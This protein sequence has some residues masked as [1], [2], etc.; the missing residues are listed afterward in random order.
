MIFKNI[1]YI[2][3]LA[4]QNPYIGKRG[5]K[6]FYKH[7]FKW[8]VGYK[9][10]RYFWSWESAPKRKKDFLKFISKQNHYGMEIERIISRADGLPF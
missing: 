1:K 6:S 5:G 3:N 10:D 7:S 2:R 8:L 4:S 9:G